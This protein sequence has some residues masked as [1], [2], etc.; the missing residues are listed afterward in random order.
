MAL[1]GN[2]LF[3]TG[4]RDILIYNVSNPAEPVLIGY[5]DTPGSGTR[6]IYVFENT[7]LVAN[8]YALDILWTPFGNPGHCSYLPG[9]VN[10]NGSFD[11]I[12]VVY[13]VSFLKGGPVPNLYCEC[14]PGAV[15]YV[16]G[17]VNGT[18]SFNGIDISYMVNY[19]KGGQAIMPC[20]NCPPVA[21]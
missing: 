11:G 7:V 3:L 9:D 2:I 8:L 1:R 15:W 14:T 18:C 10:G 12:D 19:F 6:G 5:Y 17:D 16:E 13:G 21:P 20:A 4:D